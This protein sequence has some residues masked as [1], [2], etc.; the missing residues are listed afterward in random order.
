MGQQLG[1]G[2]GN[3]YV[4]IKLSLDRIDYLFESLHELN[5][6]QEYII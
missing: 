2:T 4:R 6:I 5:L 1:I 3:I